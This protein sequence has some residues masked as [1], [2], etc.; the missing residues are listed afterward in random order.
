VKRIKVP[1]KSVS[2]RRKSNLS[3][4]PNGLEK[5]LSLKDFAD[6]VAYLEGL[7]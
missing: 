5:G 4:M 3:M 1:K 6:V 2:E 7:K